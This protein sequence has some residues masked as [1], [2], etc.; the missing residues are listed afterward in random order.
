MYATENT[1]SV[2]AHTHNLCIFYIINKVKKKKPPTRRQKKHVFVK[3]MWD[4]ARVPRD[5]WSTVVVAKH[6]GIIFSSPCLRCTFYT[7]KNN[8]EQKAS[9]GIGKNIPTTTIKGHPARPSC[10]SELN[11]LKMRLLTAVRSNGEA[12]SSWLCLL[13]GLL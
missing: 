4:R 10:F 9:K 11:S 8:N 13:V 5:I 6:V 1:A 2:N 7:Q 12:W 3:F